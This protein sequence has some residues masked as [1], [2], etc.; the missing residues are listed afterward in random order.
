VELEA[1]FAA[2]LRVEESSGAQPLPL[3][4]P[5]AAAAGGASSSGSYPMSHIEL[6]L[7]AIRHG[8]G[9]VLPK[10]VTSLQLLRK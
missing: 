4:G 5:D 6:A 2:Q 10:S 3:E 1:A 9:G 8:N 7:A